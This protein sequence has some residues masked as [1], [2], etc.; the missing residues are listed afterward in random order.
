[1]MTFTFSGTRASPP[2]RLAAVLGS[3]SRLVARAAAI[4]PHE[5]DRTVAA[6]LLSL[7]DRT[8]IQLGYNRAEIR[9]RDGV[10]F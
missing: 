4:R 5:T 2:A 3:L 7:D 8:L 6:Y 9:R 10:V 1:M